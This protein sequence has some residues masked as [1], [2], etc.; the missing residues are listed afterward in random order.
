MSRRLSSSVPNRPSN[1]PQVGAS[2]R[3]S[4]PPVVPLRRS[5]APNPLPT[6]PRSPASKKSIHP[7]KP[8]V[9]WTRVAGAIALMVMLSGVIAGSGWLA[10]QLIV[11]PRSSGWVNQWLPG[12]L[13]SKGTEQP[14][15]T[16]QAIRAELRSQG[17][18]VGE[19]LELGKNVSVDDRT[20]VSDLLLPVLEPRPNCQSDCDQI[21]ELRLYQRATD[22]RSAINEPLYSLVDQVEIAGPEE[23][24]AI[25]PLVDAK[26]DNQGS[27][28]ALPLTRVTRYDLPP[29]QGVWLNLSGKR[30]R[31]NETLAYGQIIH[32][33]PSRFHLSKKLQWTSPTGE[34]PVWKEVTG[35]G[36]SELIVNHTIGMEPQFEAY[37]IKPL[38]FL[39]S[40]VQLESISLAES[41][42][43]QSTYQ[44]ALLLARAG[45]WSTSLKWLES[46]KEKLPA[47]EWSSTAQAQFD[48]IRWHAQVTQIQAD[49]SWA[50]PSQQVLANLIDGRWERALQVFQSSI[51]ASHE[52]ADVLKADVGRL[53]NRIK[54]FGQTGSDKLEVKAWGAL[55][56][57]AQKGQPN[58]IAWLKK[59]PKVT[60]A[61]VAQ[62]SAL[63]KRLD[64]AFTEE[65][66]PDNNSSQITDTIQPIAHPLNQR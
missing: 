15:R 22:G 5:P 20:T 65:T 38:S 25:A 60:A 50:S 11:N 37:Q 42:L 29:S 63:T 9:K 6:K 33:N 53:E 52:T 59:L 26:S 64:P 58:A 16:L 12:W 2:R 10:L 44:S 51:A 35:G 21:V 48:L 39:P 49:G 45:L 17:K 62:I 54:A 4:A 1:R 19:L 46:L 23:S 30:D 31:G 55:L 24:F 7:L 61:E 14:F 40:P 66:L 3:S 47:K 57:A 41:A 13:P 32:Y 56:V 18:T 8:K 27:S 36:T 43:Q 28:R 34:A